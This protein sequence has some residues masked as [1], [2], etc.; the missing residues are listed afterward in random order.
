MMFRVHWFSL[1]IAAASFAGEGPPSAAPKTLPVA[2]LKRDTPVD[3]EKEILPILKN[4]CLACHG[5][6][7][8]KGGLVLETP[9]TILKGGDSGP[10]VVPGKSAESLLLKAAAHQDAEMIMPPRENK[11]NA[12]PLT[13]QELGL[14]KLW[15]AQGATGQVS[16]AKAIDW[17]ALPESVNPIYATALTADGQFAACGRANDV[18]IY[19]L[20]ARRLVARLVDPSLTSSVARAAAHLDLVHSLAFNPDGGLLAS[21]GYRE[22][23]LW[24]KSTHTTHVEFTSS[25]HICVI[26]SS[27]KWLVAGT[28]NG[29]VIS[30]DVATGKE[31][32]AY[33][34]HTGEV[35]RLSISPDGTRLISTG[36]DSILQLCTLP[37]LKPLLATNLGN[38]PAAIAWAGDQCVAVASDNVIRIYAGLDTN[39]LALLKELKASPTSLTSVHG[40]TTSNKTSL[41]S[42]NASGTVRIWHVE[43]G[44]V[45][46]E[47]KHGTFVTA[48]AI[49]GDGKRLVSAGTNSARLWN[50]EDGK[51]IAELKGDRYAQEALAAAERDLAFAK[52]EVAYHKTAT[53]AAEKQLK[54]AVERLNKATESFAA[55]DKSFSEKQT[56]LKTAT[57]GKDAAE[58]ALADLNAE[59]KTAIDNFQAAE[60][61]AKQSA[62]DA[63]AA[64]EKATKAK[65]SADQAAQTK[66]DTEKIAADAAA[67]A[68]KTKAASSNGVAEQIKAAAEKMAADAAA[69]ADK[70]RVFA[71]SAAADA[72]AKEKLAAEA[73]AATDKAID[74]VAVKSFALGQLKPGYDRTTNESPAKIKQASE[75]LASATNAVLAADKEF[76]KAQRTKSIA[77][78]ELLLSRAAA[79]QRTNGLNVAKSNLKAAE[80]LDQK[81]AASLNLAKKRA[82][83]SEKPIRAIAFSPDGATLATSSDDLKV[84]TWSAAS[85]APFDTCAGT[86][87]AFAAPGVLAVLQTNGQLAT[88]NLDPRWTLER[89]IGSGGPDS[90]LVD[91]INA[92]R[93]NHDSSWLATGG[94]EPS[95]SGEIKIW[96]V[97]DGSLFKSFGEVHSDA[98]LSLDF[99]ADGKYLASGAA[100]RFV[101]VVNLESG[102]LVKS[103]EGHTH[104]VL[105]VSWKR[106]GRTLAS[107]G[108]DNILKVWD[109]VSGE[110]KKN[111]EGFNKEVTSVAFVGADQALASCGDAQVRLVKENGENVRSFTGGSDFVYSAAAT[112]DGKVVVAGGQDSTLRIWDGTDGKALMSFPPAELPR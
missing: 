72:A 97:A 90:P 41:I 5:E 49:S 20:P 98:V 111:I 105:G 66:I 34:G 74:E 69:V 75:K 93:F 44:E 28:T 53:E 70:A 6:S 37:E 64:V 61:A 80:A 77:D 71:E 95:R 76:Q 13:P 33:A 19:H 38:N 22:V 50:I 18:F 73:K 67:L 39:G 99:S 87:M 107:S 104:H 101:R 36:H 78:Q 27:P 84:H 16:V 31:M 15:I 8:P 85:G 1:L 47:L 43:K 2:D 103:F 110:R 102:K 26:A 108:A 52:T 24:R 83:E 3:F 23:K 25:N 46:R 82:V 10:A 11:V 65:L 112:P 48:V 4:N 86:S 100:D 40:A 32:A 79:E 42:G 92:L 9:Q 109:F 91:R 62:A 88:C 21:G 29:L 30:W 57:D 56:A 17:Q 63:K 12:A 68:S 14:L 7:K 54:T 94:G 35:A 106:D 89:T 51:E 60:N 59:F 45:I 96:K 55:A 58:K 81:F